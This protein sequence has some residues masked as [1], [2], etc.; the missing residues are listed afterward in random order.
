[1]VFVWNNLTQDFYYC[2]KWG[3]AVLHA[4][5]MTAW[6]GASALRRNCSEIFNQD[7]LTKYMCGFMGLLVF[8]WFFM[9]PHIHAG[10][11]RA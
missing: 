7:R 11:M 5:V 2:E 10:Q 1:M 9:L 8:H 3:L 4:T 6:A